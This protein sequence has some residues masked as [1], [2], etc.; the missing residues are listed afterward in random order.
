MP[1]YILNGQ[2]TISIT[3]VVEADNAA[4]ALAMAEDMQVPNLCQSCTRTHG[5]DESTWD[6]D[7]L[8]G[9]AQEVTAEVEE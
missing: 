8:D 6:V 1:R 3:G 7:E 4:E 2:I 5:P 9:A